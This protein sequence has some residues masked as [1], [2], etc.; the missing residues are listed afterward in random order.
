MVYLLIY[1]IVQIEISLSKYK[2]GNCER[3]FDECEVEFVEDC[4][5]FDSIFSVIGL[6]CH[7]IGVCLNFF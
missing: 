4:G 1:I 5:I 3:I 7:N 6:L 2:K